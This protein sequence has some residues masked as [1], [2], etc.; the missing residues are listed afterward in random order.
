MNQDKVSATTDLYERYLQHAASVMQG[1][2]TFWISFTVHY[3]I[4]VD[5]SWIRLGCMQVNSLLETKWEIACQKYLL[6][7][8]YDFSFLSVSAFFKSDQTDPKKLGC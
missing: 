4:P 6:S 2:E 1:Q 8:D 5:E 3:S 7:S